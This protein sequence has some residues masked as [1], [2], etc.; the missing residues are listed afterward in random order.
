M[1]FLEMFQTVMREAEFKQKDVAEAM[2]YTP[3]YINDVLHGRR[4]PSVEFVE[5]LCKF[6]G[7]G[8]KGRREW[9]VAGARACGWDI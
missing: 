3:A 7:R 4:G 6:L 9:H 2:D 5:R 1:T 8:P